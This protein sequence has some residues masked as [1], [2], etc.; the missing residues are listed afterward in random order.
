MCSGNG[1]GHQVD[2]FGFCSLFKNKAGFQV[3]QATH[4]HIRP[5]NASGGIPSIQKHAINA[6]LN[7][8]IDL[9]EISSVD[10]STEALRGL[11]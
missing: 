9:Q 10:S 2:F 3:I 5:F 7:R 6:G 11:I 8:W 4:D 1:G